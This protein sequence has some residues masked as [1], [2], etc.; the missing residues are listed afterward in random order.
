MAP[1]EDWAER[2]RAHLKCAGFES[3]EFF[4]DDDAHKQITLRQA[5]L[6]TY[7]VKSDTF[8]RCLP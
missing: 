5:S 1:A 6:L 7:D 4:S 3:A 8:M 2:L